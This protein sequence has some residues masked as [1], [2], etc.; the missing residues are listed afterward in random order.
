M[1]KTSSPL[2]DIEGSPLSNL[3]ELLANIS[4]STETIIILR[5]VNIPATL[6]LRVSCQ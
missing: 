3:V 2:K 5:L 6:P 4:R 1:Q